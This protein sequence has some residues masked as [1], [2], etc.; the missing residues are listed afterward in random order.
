MMKRLT[1]VF[2]TL[3]VTLGS[4][5]AGAQSLEEGRHYRA[6]SNPVNVPIPSGKDG[7]IQEYFWYGCIHCYN[8]E[9]AVNE[10]KDQLPDSLVFEPVPVTFSDVHELHARAYYTWKQLGLPED[11]HQAIYDEIFVQNNNLRSQSAL[12]D[13]FSNYDVPRDRFEQMFSSFFVET[14]VRVARNLTAGA[15]IRGT[16][17]ILVN[18]EF[19]IESGLS[20]ISS[21]QQMLEVAQQLALQLAED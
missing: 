14:K 12:A 5:V 3:L 8:L 20:G 13:F 2:G 15:Q 1:L 19:L 11:T 18:G 16:P 10:F 7:V 21:N 4:A 17:S 9:P 6:L